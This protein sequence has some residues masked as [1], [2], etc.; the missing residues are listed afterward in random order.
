MGPGPHAPGLGVDSSVSLWGTTV[1]RWPSRLWVRDM[2][3]APDP[4]QARSLVVRDH[5]LICS[6]LLGFPGD[7]LP[8][9]TSLLVHPYL[10]PACPGKKGWGGWGVPSSPSK[11]NSLE[12]FL[13][14]FDPDQSP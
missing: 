6:G 9:R 3:V 13:S 12:L 1:P 14:L 11:K 2:C 10:G 4:G 7:V 5:S 8:E